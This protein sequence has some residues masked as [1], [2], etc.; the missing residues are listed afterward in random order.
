MTTGD[1]QIAK[2]TLRS[3]KWLV[4]ATGSMSHDLHTQTR[5]RHAAALGVKQTDSGKNLQSCKG[6]SG[7]PATA[8]RETC[9]WPSISSFY[10]TSGFKNKLTRD[11][12]REVGQA[13]TTLRDSKDTWKCVLVGRTFKYPWELC[14]GLSLVQDSDHPTPRK[15][16]KQTDQNIFRGPCYCEVTSW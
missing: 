6:E 2:Q 8:N 1:F 5:A 7:L 16:K 3:F 4:W 11:G 12:K 10:L 14:C 15:N 13:T 9:R